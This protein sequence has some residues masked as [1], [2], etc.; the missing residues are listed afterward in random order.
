MER[1]KRTAEA[2]RE[3]ETRE[4]L[5]A[6]SLGTLE[7]AVDIGP[8]ASPNDP[9]PE[10]LG[11]YEIVRRLGQGAMGV[12]YEA[13]DPRARSP[14]AIKSVSRLSPEAL[15]RFKQEFRALARFQHPNVVSLYELHLEDN[16]LFFTME[17][18]RGVDFI[19]SLCGSR[20][21]PESPR[22]RPCRDYDRLRLALR[23]LAEGVHAIHLGGILHRDIKPSNVLVTEQGRVV[24]LDFGLVRQHDMEADLGVTDDGAVLGTPLYMSPEQAMGDRLG[25]PS[26]WY[27]VGELMYQALTGQTPF[28]GKGM[29]ALL[30]AK[31][32]DR[33]PAPSGMVTGIPHDLEALCMDLLERDPD[34]RPTGDE[35]LQRTAA[36]KNERAARD[37]VPRR[38][39]DAST[40][41]LVLMFLGR[42]AECQSL[43]EALAESRNGRPVVVLVD[44]VS[45]MGKTALVQRFLYEASREPDT[46]VLSGKCSERESIP[47]KALDSVMDTLC[48]YLRG[49]ASAAEVEALLPRDPRAVAR[50]FPVLLS[51]PSVATAPEREVLGLDPAQARRRAFGSL[52]ELWGRIADRS[53]LVVHIDDLQWTDLDSAILLDALVRDPDAPAMLLVAAFRSGA[54]QG[55]GPL[56]RLVDE[57]TVDDQ[58]DVRRVHVGPMSRAEASDLALSML[59]ERTKRHRALADEVAREAEGSPFF[60]GELVRY[61]RRVAD[62]G[63][64]P[65]TDSSSAVSLDSVI[66]HRLA[67]LPT[68]VRRLLEVIA[69]AGGRISQGIA[70]SVA[71]GEQR[72]RSALSRLRSESLARLQG[73]RDEDPVEIYHDRIREAAL[74]AIERGTLAEIHLALGRALESSGDADA[75]ALS[76]HF[77]QAGEDHRAT[78]HTLDAAEQA[79]AAL[80]FDRAAELYH[81]AIDLHALPSEE[82][83]EIEARLAEALA[84]AGRLYDS[85]K[86]YLRASDQG[87]DRE[88]LE[89]TRRAA[90]RMLSSGH[91]DEGRVVLETVLESV[92]LSLPQSTGRAVASLLRNKVAIGLRGLKYTLRDQSE[93]P[94]EQLE[95]LDAAWTASRGLVYTDGLLGADFHTRHLRMALRAGEPARLS[96]ALAAEAHMQAVIGGDKKLPR[97]QEILAQAEA[98]AE[99]A[100]QAAAR[101]FV[102]E[103]RGHVWISVGHWPKAL[104]DLD[105]ATAIFREQ[106]TGMAQVLSY[107][108]AHAAICLYYMGRA[109]ELALRAPRL[110]RESQERANPF[111]QG[112]AR[113]LLGN[114]ALLAPDRVEEAE[115]QLAIYRRESW[116]LEAQRINCVAQTAAL[117]RYVGDPA[118]AWEICE[119]DFPEIKKLSVLA[120]ALAKAEFWQW[121]GGCALAGATATNDPQPLLAEA[122]RNASKLLKHTSVYAR[123]YGHLTRAGAVA[124]AGNDEAAVADLR[125]AIELAAS[126]R[127][128]THV[129]AAQA[130]LAAIVGGSEADE[131]LAESNAYMEREGIVRPERFIDM[132]AP[133]FVRQ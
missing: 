98:L 11:R 108:E 65:I 24:L 104:A 12:V 17:L 32:E 84:N 75:V 51:I 9:D 90:D 23:Q 76:H 127:M 95:R 62:E 126:R 48:V 116:N 1:N 99:Q 91:S 22:R 125:Q 20:I 69:V 88:H 54:D 38:P 28:Q 3:Q 109:K 72:D 133:G 106:C 4:V 103:C 46:V 6:P 119:Q 118:G 78:R 129:A 27:G 61:A 29:L 80:A 92:G 112:Y 110:L 85:A 81:A 128:G 71:M 15:Y 93:V 132:A 10:R 121:R 94:P 35:V 16:R 77:R 44:G 66:R 13:I 124:L 107:C 115:E 30:A 123:A 21:T 130:R 56:A 86:A 7:D 19:T 2:L 101:G 100:D 111:V 60:V 102:V 59:G 57:F 82:V 53:R 131:L 63:E 117:R 33:P 5:R 26:D 83:P 113:G 41:G 52:R 18:V 120:A 73:P 68:D 122:R 43:H 25:P 47:Y 87:R 64:I 74:R 34:L 39:T 45:G 49:L 14:L 31:Q 55:D 97:A 114:L 67:A 105:K 70:L 40:S 96:R 37:G 89:W 36:F 50:L 42:D 79:E 8:P 58:V